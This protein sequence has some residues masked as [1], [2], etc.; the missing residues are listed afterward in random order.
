MVEVGRSRR[1]RAVRVANW[2][3]LL[4]ETNEHDLIMCWFRYLRKFRY[5]ANI[6]QYLLSMN[7][8]SQRAKHWSRS[9]LRQALVWWKQVA[10]LMRGSACKSGSTWQVYLSRDDDLIPIFGTNEPTSSFFKKKSQRHDRQCYCRIADE[11]L[12]AKFSFE[13][14]TKRKP[15]ANPRLFFTYG[16]FGFHGDF[17]TAG[18]EWIKNYKLGVDI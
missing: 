12:A 18:M 17:N 2:R 7:V 5:G 15:H 1:R 13:R 9:L 6:Y 11:A 16:T 3:R 10:A 14:Q 8:P 4:P